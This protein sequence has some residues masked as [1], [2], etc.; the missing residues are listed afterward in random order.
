MIKRGI[1]VKLDPILKRRLAIATIIVALIVIFLPMPFGHL[2]TTLSQEPIATMPAVP[3]KP[4][5]KLTQVPEQANVIPTQQ[6]QHAKLAQPLSLSPKEVDQKL[7]ESYNIN[8]PSVS[9]E[10]KPAIV[11]ST[12]K[13]KTPP[14]KT[15]ELKQLKHSKSTHKVSAVSKKKAKLQLAKH[16]QQPLQNIED[17]NQNALAEITPQFQLRRSNENSGNAVIEQHVKQNIAAAKSMSKAWVAQLGSFADPKRTNQLITE[18]KSKGYTAF[19]YKTK[20]NGQVK[21]RVYMGPYLSQNKAVNELK[22][23]NKKFRLSGYVHT[24]KANKLS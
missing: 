4:E 13:N 14:T 2:R 24:F 12:K 20:V 5:I 3:E 22:I 6:P 17:L 18:L 23:V 16:K 7:L 10:V 9:D 1:N 11:D 15:V 19:S 8:P 21:Y